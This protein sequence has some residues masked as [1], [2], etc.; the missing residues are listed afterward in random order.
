MLVTNWYWFI[1]LNIIPWFFSFCTYFFCSCHNISDDNSVES[2]VINACG[3]S[4]VINA[5]ESERMRLMYK[6]KQMG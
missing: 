1:Q 3:E 6:N 2:S 5:I 4:S